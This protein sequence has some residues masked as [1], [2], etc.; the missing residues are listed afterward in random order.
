MEKFWTIMVANMY[1]NLNERFYTYEAAQAEAIRRAQKA[2]GLTFVVLELK[3]YAQGVSTTEVSYTDLSYKEIE[4]EGDDGEGNITVS[5]TNLT[6]I[7]DSILINE[8]ISI[9]S[10]KDG[11]IILN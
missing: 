2:P 4:V 9:N 11:D 3:G 5:E 1:T 7:D 6:D 10:D 8:D